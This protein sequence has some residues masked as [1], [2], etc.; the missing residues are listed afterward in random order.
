MISSSRIIFA[1]ALGYFFFSESLSLRIVT[2]GIMIIASIIGI[3][4]LQKMKT[5]QLIE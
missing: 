1:A 5:G 2:G 3:S 4:M